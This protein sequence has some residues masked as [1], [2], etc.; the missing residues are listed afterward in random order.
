M[1]R[2][3]VR[4]KL[5]EASP[6]S[7]GI[8]KSPAPDIVRLALSPNSPKYVNSHAEQCGQHV[9]GRH[10]TV[11]RKPPVPSKNRLLVPS[12]GSPVVVLITRTSSQPVPTRV[13][14]RASAQ[15]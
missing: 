1:A 10:P 12:S 9:C 11:K 6:K 14:Y 8:A 4:K 7:P 2:V 3:S 5:F 13:Q 15:N